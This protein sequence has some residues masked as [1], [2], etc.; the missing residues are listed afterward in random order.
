MTTENLVVYSAIF[1]GK[2]KYKEPPAGRYQVVLFT[3]GAVKASPHVK[4]VRIPLLGDPRRQSR[5]FK[6]LSHEHFP[7]ARY[8]LWM[9]GSIEAV[10]IDI[11]AEV[12]KHLENADVAA[13]SHNVR[14]CLYEEAEAIIEYK[15]ADPKV[16]RD[17]ADRYRADGY[18]AGA[19]LCEC[20]V[21]FRR[22]TPAV[23]AFNRFWYEELK[24]ASNRDQLSFL[25]SIWK[26]GVRFKAIEGNILR[27]EAGPGFYVR[28]HEF[29]DPPV[30]AKL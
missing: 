1:G 16:I 26:T 3:D 24:K 14:K 8:T 21:L 22:N 6:M 5:Y 10:G 4:I 9:D 27:G 28:R 7:E 12:E 29:F 15:L 20:G 18:P 23:A 13:F 2:D 19:G 25:Y 17:Q 30:E 11:R